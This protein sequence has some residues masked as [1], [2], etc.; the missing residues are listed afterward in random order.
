[1]LMLYF[2]VLHEQFNL[3]TKYFLMEWQTRAVKSSWLWGGND[4][5]HNS[6]KL[7]ANKVVYGYVVNGRRLSLK[8]LIV[9]FKYKE[10]SRILQPI[11]TFSPLPPPPLNA[12]VY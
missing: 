4:V 5:I 12:N 11:H 6:C 1:M 7:G 8:L 9:K 10:R 3:H 2:L